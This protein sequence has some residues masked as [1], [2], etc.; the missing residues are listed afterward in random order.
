MQI[1]NT[2]FNLPIPKEVDVFIENIPWC[3]GVFYEPS[4]AKKMGKKKKPTIVLNKDD[5]K[6][7]IFVHE[8]GHYL[9]WKETKFDNA[10]FCERQKQADIYG[11]KW[12]KNIT[13]K[14]IQGLYYDINGR[15][16]NTLSKEQK[17]VRNKTINE[18]IEK[19]KRRH[20]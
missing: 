9:H 12:Y 2:I 13:G 5:A 4:V 15:G 1:Y 7:N 14:R 8:M 6:K 11:R 20:T 10:G 16:K 17:K 3:K 18:A 19:F